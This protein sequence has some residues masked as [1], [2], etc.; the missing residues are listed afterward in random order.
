VR[1]QENQAPA[2]PSVLAQL[3]AGRPVLSLGVR[4]ARTGDVA[5]MASGA[6]Y[7]VIWI[8]LEHSSMSIDCAAQIAAT[9]TDLGMAAWVRVP[10]REYGV[11]GRLLDS[12]A[13][14]IISPKVETADEARLVAAACRFPPQGQRSAIALLPQSRFVRVPAAELTRRSN[15]GLVVQILLESARG[16]ANAD[17]IAA[18]EG[19]DLLGVGMNDLSADLGCPGDLRDPRVLAA[20]EQVAAAAARH[21]K[22]AVIGGVADAAQFQEFLDGGFAPLVFAG[23]DTDVLAGG[24][25][26]RVAEWRG[27]FP[28]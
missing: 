24:M 11:I 9:A 10:E 28:Q 15:E 3:A 25:A 19:V 16:V 23:I 8:D 2:G 7:Q 20:C 27:R 12:G 17:E 14:G 4:H 26:Q 6:G 21:G 5:R 22:I 18:V 13:T 1:Y